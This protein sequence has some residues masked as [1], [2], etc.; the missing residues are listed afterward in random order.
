M[1]TEEETSPTVPGLHYIADY[2]TPSAQQHYLNIIDQQPWSNELKR[3]VQHYGYRYDYRRKQVDYDL[4]LGPLPEWAAAL[5]QRLHAD[6]HAPAMPDQLIINEYQP[7]QGIASHVDCVPCFGDTIISLSLGS[8][9]VMELSQLTS[10]RQVSL[11]LEVGSLLVLRAEARYDW[12]HGISARRS[13]QHQG[14][15]II[16][17]RRVSL[18]FRTVLLNTTAT[19]RL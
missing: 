8:A 13:D 10:S 16:R 18:T 6:M 1:F 4:Y 3:R 19:T 2:L 9:C 14:Q 11:L 17:Q 7:G 15:T 12:K 5:V